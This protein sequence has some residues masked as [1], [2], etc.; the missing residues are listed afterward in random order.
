MD[1]NKYL[2]ETIVLFIVSV[3]IFFLLLVSIIKNRK[4]ANKKEDDVPLIS[5]DGYATT[6]DEIKKMSEQGQ[7]ELEEARKELDVKMYNNLI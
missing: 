7:R 6:H 5:L 2:Y 4:R 1:T 3:I